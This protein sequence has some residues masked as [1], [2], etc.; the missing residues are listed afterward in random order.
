MSTR[1]WRP[2]ASK[3]VQLLAA[4]KLAPQHW[5]KVMLPCAWNALFLKTCLLVHAKP[6]VFKLGVAA[7]DSRNA[8]LA[9]LCLINVKETPFRKNAQTSKPKSGGRCA[10]T[11]HQTIKFPCPRPRSATTQKNITPQNIT[12]WVQRGFRCFPYER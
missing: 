11:D 2:S 10:S 8:L 12:P 7:P 4:E 3:C 6:Y 5:E 1:N 9:N